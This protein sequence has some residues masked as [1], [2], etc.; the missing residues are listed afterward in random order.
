M[1]SDPTPTASGSHGLAK[2]VTVRV[3]VEVDPPAVNLT[4]TVSLPAVVQTPSS[5]TVQPWLTEAAVPAVTDP[6][7]PVTFTV[8]VFVPNVWVNTMDAG[9]PATTVLADVV[10]AMCGPV[11]WA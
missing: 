2:T 6:G 1:V 8:H 9:M 5:S 10:A 7:S 11:D 3:M 4:V